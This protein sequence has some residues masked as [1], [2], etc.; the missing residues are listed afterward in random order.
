MKKFMDKDFLLETET[1]KTLFHEFAAKEPIYD[2]HCHLIPQQIAENKKFA[3]LTEIWLGGDHYKWRQMRTF[4][5]DEKY[6]TGNGEPYEK[7]MA[8]TR[9]IENLI[10]NPLY[11]WTHLE[12]QRYFGIYEPLTEKTAPAIWEK[13]NAM[14]QKDELSVKGIFEKMNVYAVGTTDDPADSLEYHKAIAAGTA[15]IGKIKTKVI[16]SFRPDKAININLPT[17]PGYIAALAKASGMEI[18]TAKDVAK[19]LKN[20]L[21]FF[22]ENGCR[23]SDH[24]LEYA[25]FKI[26]SEAEIEAAFQKG[27]KGEAL[28]KD[29][30]DAYRTMI[31]TELAGAYKE[32]NIVMQYH[33]ASIRDNNRPMFNKLGPDTGFDAVHDHQL[34]EGLSSLMS[35]IADSVGLPKTVLYTLN[36]KDYY[37]IGTLMGCYQGDGIKG[38]IQMGSAWW[39]CDH[40]DG[41]T[42]QMTILGN[43]GMLPAF[44]GMLTDSRSFLSY[45]RHEY[46]RRILC[47]I[48]GGWVEN[49]EYPADTEQLGKIIKDI[50]FE[51]AKAY[52]G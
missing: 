37:P 11:H 14:L 16:P 27:L 42:Q 51:N 15:P 35:H 50:S 7:F 17:F 9:T 28:S 26:L 32:K 52:F 2:F 25:P 31:L 20:R 19:A 13:A 12:L 43:L 21:D 24:A 3:N 49:G 22:A 48:V 10:G 38:K 33:I 5:I 45:P 30:I 18:K 41:M 8:W 1:A 39:F 4:G 6:I 23:A 44:V 29:E 40:K 34:S 46:F 47:N 36:P